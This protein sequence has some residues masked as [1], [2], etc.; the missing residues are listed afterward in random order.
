MGNYTL[1]ISKDAQKEISYFY[2]LNDN[3]IIK[4][5]EKN[6]EELIEHP[7]TG[8]GKVEQLRGDLAGCWSRRINKKHRYS[9]CHFCRRSLWQLVGLYELSPAID[10]PN[11][12][13]VA[14][15]S[16]KIYM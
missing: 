4:K 7:T 16:S 2:K 1:I 15:F 5:L 8:T 9:F 14:F 13:V 6:F 10:L 12:V 3:A 11:H